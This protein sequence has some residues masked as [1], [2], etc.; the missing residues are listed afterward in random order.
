MEADGKGCS[1]TLFFQAADESDIFP[2]LWGIRNREHQREIGRD[3]LSRDR[4]FGCA[5]PQPSP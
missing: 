5:F 2:N 4:L 3:E 1:Q